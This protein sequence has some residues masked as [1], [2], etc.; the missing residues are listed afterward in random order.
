MFSKINGSN[1]FYMSVLLC[2]YSAFSGAVTTVIELDK[3][4]YAVV[5][6][7]ELKID[8]FNQALRN[9]VKKK[10]YH[11][12]IPEGAIE[13]IQ[14]EIAK[15][16]LA[17][18]LYIQ[19]G[20]K[21][22]YKP[23]K[24]WVDDNLEITLEKYKKQY[25]QSEKWN[26]YK[27]KFVTGYKSHLE[28]INIVDQINRSFEVATEPAETELRQYY[29][30]NKDKFTTPERLHVSVILLGVE[31][32]SPIE[33]WDDA[34]DKGRDIYRQLQEGAKFEDMARQ[35]SSDSASAKNGGDMGYLH[36]GMLSLKSQEI[37]NELKI[38]EISKPEKLL[39]GVAIFRL[40]D[41]K[42]PVLND[43]NTVKTQLIGLWK[44]N[45][46]EQNKKI[47]TDSL[48][49]SSKIRINSRYFDKN[50]LDKLQ[51]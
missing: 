27:E 17:N 15:K 29:E 39:E 49:Q 42:I 16:I 36:K 32:S 43:I 51:Y 37:L 45:K 7:T 33:K 48:W 12:K 23:E 25:G 19:E 35:F 22:G 3:S 21:R 20:K 2:L 26:E 34:M 9:E 18:I 46:E 38:N 28:S 6:D 40:I 44:R 47:L 24:K 30:N 11:G 4:V 31:P 5:N 8:E 1:R 50:N 10:Y 13:K 41:R 14:L